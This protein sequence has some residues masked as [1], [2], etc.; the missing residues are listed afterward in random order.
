MVI[1]QGTILDRIF[2][3]TYQSRHN[4]KRGKRELVENQ[5]YMIEIKLPV[6]LEKLSN[7]FY[8]DEDFDLDN[9]KRT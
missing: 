2:Y 7:K 8:N 4:I 1:Y 6:Q 5:E 9:S 3:N